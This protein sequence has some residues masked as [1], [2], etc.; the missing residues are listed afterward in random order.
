MAP[1]IRE[2]DLIAQVTGL[3]RH[4]ILLS[5]ES[6]WLVPA[7][8]RDGERLYLDVDV[9]RARL[10]HEL[11]DDLALGEDALP[12]VLS[13]IDQLH[14]ARFRLNV[15]LDALLAQPEDHRTPVLEALLQRL[16]ETTPKREL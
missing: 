14:A 11:R 13:L 3:T 12:V 6:G 9:A 1:M 8:E 5:V 15:L 7:D 10:I 4:E 2:S 16:S